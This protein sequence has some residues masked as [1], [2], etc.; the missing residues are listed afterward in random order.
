M[1]EPHLGR[2]GAL[3]LR[4]ARVFEDQC[5]LPFVLEEEY[6][7][8]SVWPIRV[9]DPFNEKCPLLIVEPNVAV[10][11]LWQTNRSILAWPHF[12]VAS[13]APIKASRRR[14]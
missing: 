7:L 3:L 4:N 9:L 11:H 1:L 2:L 5:P 8:L 14:L 12:A 10:D 13:V 6:P